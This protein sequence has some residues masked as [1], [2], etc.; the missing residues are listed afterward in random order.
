MALFDKNKVETL[1]NKTIKYVKSKYAYVSVG[2]HVS[3]VVIDEELP[4]CIKREIIDPQEEEFDPTHVFF[5]FSIKSMEDMQICNNWMMHI[6]GKQTE[7]RYLS[8]MSVLVYFSL[9]DRLHRYRMYQEMNFQITKKSLVIS[10]NKFLM[11]APSIIK[12]FDIPF[13]SIQ[14]YRLKDVVDAANLYD[15]FHW[16]V[17][18]I[19]IQRAFR[20]YLDKL[21]VAATI[22]Q[23]K[24][25]HVISDPSCLPCKNM[26][27]WNFKSLNE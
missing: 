24:W 3:N 13:S 26:L 15:N 9:L 17:R 27:I 10:I 14:S 18:A 5:E 23:R 1:L 11:R 16:T 22:I 7:T 21:N 20:I 6:S 19:K 4:H 8:L 25:R 2:L 12:Q